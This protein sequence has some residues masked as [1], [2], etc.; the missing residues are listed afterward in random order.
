MRRTAWSCRGTRLPAFRPITPRRSSTTRYRCW[1]PSPPPTI[2][3]WHGRRHDVTDTDHEV[4]PFPEL[5]PVDA[6]RELD[7]FV[8]AMRRLQDI[9][10]STNPDGALWA[11]AAERIED[12]SAL[13]EV[14]RAPEGVA[15]A[16]R[17]G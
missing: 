12:L 4:H 8:A 7:R 3:S 6:P 9:A 1:R 10:V 2:C 5:K 11:A 15:P 16:G 13:L 17:A 14:H